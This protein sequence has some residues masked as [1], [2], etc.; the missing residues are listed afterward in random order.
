MM[1]A[2]ER[3][4]ALLLKETKNCLLPSRGEAVWHNTWWGVAGGWKPPFS[5]GL[6]NQKLLHQHKY[7]FD[8]ACCRRAALLL[9]YSVTRWSPCTWVDT[10]QLDILVKTLR[11]QVLLGRI[12]CSDILERKW[13]KVGALCDCIHTQ[14]WLYHHRWE[15]RRRLTSTQIT[16]VR[17]LGLV[18]RTFI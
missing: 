3:M 7:E 9:L 8:G 11:N 2:Q 14:C 12:Y 1:G 18:L 10:A 16:Q 4:R 6:M 15:K 13:L 5:L 17:I